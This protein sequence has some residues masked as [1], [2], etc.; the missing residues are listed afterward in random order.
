MTLLRRLL[1]QL[2]LIWACLLIV[3]VAAAWGVRGLRQD[4]SVALSNYERL[5]QLYAVGFYLQSARAAL[6]LDFPD[7]PQARL[8][9][10]RAQQQFGEAWPNDETAAAATNALAAA[11][12]AM[13]APRPTMTA[14]DR[15]LAELNTLVE[16]LRQ[17]IDSAQRT[18][19]RRQRATL[20]TVIGVAVVAGGVSAWVGRRQLRAVL[21]PLSELSAAVRRVASGRLDTPLALAAADA[22]FARLANDFNAMAGELRAGREALQARVEAATRAAVQSERLAGVGMLA[23]GVAHE[24]N[25]PLSVIAARVELLLAKGPEPVTAAGLNE[26]LDEAFR[27]KRIIERLLQLSRAPAGHRTTVDLAV[28]TG[29]V[30]DAVRQTP[31]AA[32]R[33]WRV[34]VRPV[35]VRADEGELRQVV[36]NLLLNA[37]QFTPA[38]GTID[39]RVVKQAGE[40]TLVVT[41]DGAGIEAGAMGRLFEPFYSTRVGESRGTGLGLAISR[42]VVEGHGGR[43]DA[44]S[45]GA[46]QG[47][48]FIVRLPAVEDA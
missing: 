18:A 35:A 40:A 39:V 1:G 11:A 12:V 19:D 30:V 23:A 24:I 27:C 3:A 38:G 21:R 45:A 33:Q 36:L 17:Q 42:A 34:C 10:R 22:E 47:S 26:V 37:V 2:A 41:D 28:L 20:V 25:N 6:T 7:V 29:S 15:P 43:I 48:R 14:L 5:R 32:A 13:D 44:E 4:F 16:T 9:A 8:N 46:A 31:A